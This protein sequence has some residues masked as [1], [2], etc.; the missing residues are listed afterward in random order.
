MSK[1][2]PNMKLAAIAPKA[3]TAKS[4]H[5]LSASQ[6]E[7]RQP[8]QP[9]SQASLD[10]MLTAARKL[11]IERGGEDFTL[12]EVSNIGKVSTGSIYHRFAGKDEL[13]RAVIE[14]ELAVMADDENRAFAEALNN[15][16]NLDAYIPAYVR[17][18]SDI[19]RKNSLMLRLAMRRATVDHEVSHS[20]NRRH[21]ESTESLACDLSRFRGEI[22]GDADTKA[23]MAFHIAFST[24]V[25]QLSLESIDPAANH[26]DWSMMLHELSEMILAYLKFGRSR[27]TS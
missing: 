14:R 20:G 4:E 5:A 24:L 26:S 21:R 2:K 16:A 6:T 15:S 10:R 11:M 9:R 3:G 27:S 23:A 17:A 8:M 25:R 22:S 12:Q 18:F 13:V 1:P 19:L 7:S